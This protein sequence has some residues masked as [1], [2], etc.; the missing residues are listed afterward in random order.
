LGAPL[1]LLCRLPGGPPPGSAIRLGASHWLRPLAEPPSGLPG[2]LA[3]QALA[4][5]AAELFFETELLS[6]IV[7]PAKVGI[8]FHSFSLLVNNYF[9][10]EKF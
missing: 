6:R 2:A 3:A 1:S 8:Q 7:I 5:Q 4:E 10:K 9:R